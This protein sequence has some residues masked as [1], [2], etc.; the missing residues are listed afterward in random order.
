MKLPSY[1]THGAFSNQSRDK[2][3]KISQKAGRRALVLISVDTSAQSRPGSHHLHEGGPPAFDS[4]CRPM[5]FS[6]F[7]CASRKS[8]CLLKS[9]IYIHRHFLDALN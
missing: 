2:T 4:F 7:V 9:F 1:W 5:H 3:L 6:V 8:V